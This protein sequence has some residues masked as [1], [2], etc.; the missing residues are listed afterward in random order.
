MAQGGYPS[1]VNVI[2]STLESKVS[3]K[4]P[5]FTVYGAGT[6]VGQLADDG[7]KAFASTTKTIVAGTAMDGNN[8][9]P[10]MNMIAVMKS[11]SNQGITQQRIHGYVRIFDTETAYNKFYG[12]GVDPEVTV[13][14]LDMDSENHSAGINFAAKA[15]SSGDTYLQASGNNGYVNSGF[16]ME[17]NFDSSLV[18]GVQYTEGNYVNVYTPYGMGAIVQ[19]YSK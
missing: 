18:V 4:E 11:G 5:W 13:Y 19:M 2:S 8:P 6:I 10:Q 15:M 7:E 9:V 12:I 3:G 14:G 16:D 17:T 1:H